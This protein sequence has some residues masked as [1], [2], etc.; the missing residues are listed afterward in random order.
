VC[1]ELKIPESEAVETEVQVD[2]ERSLAHPGTGKEK[3][4]SGKGWGKAGATTS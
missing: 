3:V 2:E 1:E 4:E